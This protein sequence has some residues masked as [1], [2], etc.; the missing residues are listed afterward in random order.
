VTRVD[1]ATNRVVATIPLRLPSPVGSEADRFDFL[2]FDL[3]TGAGAVWVITDRGAVARIDP[4]TNRVAAYIPIPGENCGGIAVAGDRVWFANCV[5]GVWAIDPATNTVVEKTR[6]HGHHPVEAESL[7]PAA[8]DLWAAG[9]NLR[10]TGDPASP[11]G[12]A[13]GGAVARIDPATGHILATFDFDHS[14]FLAAAGGGFVWVAAGRDRLYRIDTRTSVVSGPFALGG[15]L[16][17]VDHGSGWVVT[18]DGALERVP[19]P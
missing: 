8:G 14:A 18:P 2:P 13:R 19:L 6:V 1:P 10:K 4:A 7:L 3:T 11:Y 5:S 16:W 9:A 12:F 17:A 15:M